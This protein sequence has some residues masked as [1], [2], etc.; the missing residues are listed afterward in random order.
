MPSTA[1]SRR[2]REPLNSCSRTKAER[3]VYSL[4]T[5]Y[6]RKLTLAVHRLKHPY[7]CASRTSPSAGQPRPPLCSGIAHGT[8]PPRALSQNSYGICTRRAGKLYRARSR[9]Y[10]RRF[11]QVNMRWKALAEIYT[12]HSFALLSNEVLAATW[13]ICTRRAGKLYKARSRLYRSQILQVN[14]KYSLE[15]FRRALLCT[16]L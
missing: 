11:L 2:R 12:M 3:Q 5:G 14:T 16:V 8:N 13:G 1:E 10:R 4:W 9:L 15:S 6:R 7:P